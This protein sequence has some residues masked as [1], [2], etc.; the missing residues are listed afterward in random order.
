MH[1]YNLPVSKYAYTYGLDLPY[2]FLCK[3]CNLRNSYLFVK[4][5][6]DSDLLLL[7]FLVTAVIFKLL[8]MSLL[9]RCF[10]ELNGILNY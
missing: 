6:I 2:I 10:L 4:W 8:D 3:L 5:R 9:S 1:Y 7:H